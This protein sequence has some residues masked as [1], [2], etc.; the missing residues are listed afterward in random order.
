[1]KTPYYEHRSMY[2]DDKMSVEC[3]L[4]SYK[5]TS[6]E[7]DYRLVTKTVLIGQHLKVCL[8]LLLI[9]STLVAPL[10]LIPVGSVENKEQPI[11]YMQEERDREDSLRKENPIKRNSNYVP[12]R[13]RPIIVP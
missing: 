13:V 1:M 12:V 6:L 5:G 10:L 11:R 3:F 7:G 8:G 4:R 2:R 9:F